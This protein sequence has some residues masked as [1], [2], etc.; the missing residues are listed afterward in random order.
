[1]KQYKQ[2]VEIRS[3]IQK[4]LTSTYPIQKT[5]TNIPKWA[6]TAR[7]GFKDEEWGEM[8]HNSSLRQ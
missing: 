6:E 1:M 2:N 4:A 5:K 3:E 7:K 8:E